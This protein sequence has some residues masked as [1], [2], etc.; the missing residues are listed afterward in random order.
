[1]LFLCHRLPLLFA[2][3]LAEEPELL[4][5][6]ASIGKD[7]AE[8]AAKIA[9]AEGQE[10]TAGDTQ[11]AP[12]EAEKIPGSVLG[13]EVVVEEKVPLQTM[14]PPPQFGTSVAALQSSSSNL[15]L[16]LAQPGLGA[17]G[18]ST[19]VS[20]NLDEEI[21]R[22]MAPLSQ[23]AEE[24]DDS[25]SVVLDLSFLESVATGIKEMQNMYN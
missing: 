20:A 1:M 21:Q 3:P 7:A 4:E 9:A 2:V 22:I 11:E 15:A 10:H 13:S 16:V 17:P 24:A 14:S 6:V 5:E 18:S 8:E 12:K 23:R 25:V 19:A